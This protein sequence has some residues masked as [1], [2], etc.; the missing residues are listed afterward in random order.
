MIVIAII[1]GCIIGALIGINAPMIPYTYST[2][3]AIAVVAALDSV[4]AIAYTR[5][6]AAWQGPDWYPSRRSRRRDRS[7]RR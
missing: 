7:C 3:L 4:F 6:P 1:F 2:F 5:S